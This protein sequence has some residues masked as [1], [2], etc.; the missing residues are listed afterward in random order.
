ME[1]E[2]SVEAVCVVCLEDETNTC[3][4]RKPNEG[5]NHVLAEAQPAKVRIDEDVGNPGEG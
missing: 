2:M 5:L 4:L 1:A 3:Q